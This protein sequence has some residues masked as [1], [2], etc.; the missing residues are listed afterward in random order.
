MSATVPNR[1]ALRSLRV[2]VWSY[3]FSSMQAWSAD[4]VFY[5]EKPEEMNAVQIFCDFIQLE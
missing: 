5:E 2:N 1:P 4:C 3:S